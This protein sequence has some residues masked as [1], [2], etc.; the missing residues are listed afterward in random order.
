MQNN[1]HDI[2][3]EADIKLM[4]DSFYNKVNNDE[5]LSQ[6][7]NDFSQVDWNSH[8][9][10][11]YRFWNTLILGKQSYK[12]NPFAKHVPLPIN[13]KHFTRWLQL[14]E[15]NIDLHFTGEVA[16]NTKIRAKSIAYIFQSKLEFMNSHK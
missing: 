12:G 10:T 16:E 4:V 1:K 8:L 7:F 3:T 2:Q 9:P 14:F 6:V 5:L 11:M 13:K 15:E